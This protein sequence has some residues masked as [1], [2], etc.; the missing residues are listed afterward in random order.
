MLLDQIKNGSTGLNT[1]IEQ[2]DIPNLVWEDNLS[3]SYEDKKILIPKKSNF[4]NNSYDIIKLDKVNSEF[5][6]L[7]KKHI[8]L[9]KNINR[10]NKFL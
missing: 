8:F 5:S 2:T 1:T 9:S 10:W 4:I 3:L 6:K 7:N